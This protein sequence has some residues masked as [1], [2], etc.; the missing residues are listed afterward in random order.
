MGGSAI[1]LDVLFPT[2]MNWAFLAEGKQSYD[3]KLILPKAVPAPTHCKLQAQ[4]AQNGT[5][6][7]I[8]RQ[9]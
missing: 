7:L 2:Q 6:S 1:F 5:A 8:P 4:K 3:P 9:E